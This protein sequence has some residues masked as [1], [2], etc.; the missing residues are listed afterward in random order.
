MVLS[1]S[2]FPLSFSIALSFCD[3]DEQKMIKNIVALQRLPQHL[4]QTLTILSTWLFK[5]RKETHCN[6]YYKLHTV[7]CKVIKL[8]KNICQCEQLN[9]DKIFCIILISLSIVV[10]FGR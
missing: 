2:W 9:Y 10:R 5:F 7:I 4:Q 3:Q 8:Y 6:L 1:T